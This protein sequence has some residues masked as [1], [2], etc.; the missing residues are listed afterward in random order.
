METQITT[1]QPHYNEEILEMFTEADWAWWNDRLNED[2][3]QELSKL[4]IG[5]WLNIVDEARQY[6]ISSVLY[7]D[8]KRLIDEDDIRLIKTTTFF[9][10]SIIAKRRN[11]LKMT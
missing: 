11:L 5:Q 3:R 2:D 4:V 6:S 9:G 8:F 7:W 1:T 10:T